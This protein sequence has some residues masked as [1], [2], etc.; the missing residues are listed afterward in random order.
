M[1]EKADRSS[2]GESVIPRIPPSKRRRIQT[3]LRRWWWLLLLLFACCTLIITLPLVYVGFPNIAQ[4][5]VD[6]SSLEITS[7]LLTAP[8]ANSLHIRLDERLHNPSMYHPRLDAFN[9]SLFLEDT[10]PNIKPYAYITV[11]AVHA[12]P[13]ATFTIDQALAV[14][15]MDQFTRYTVLVMNSEEYRLAIRGRTGL[16]QTGLRKTNVNYNEVVTMKGLNKLR[17]FNV[18]EFKVLL[19][20]DPDGANLVGTVFIP[21]P[22]VMLLEMGN[23]TMN[24]FVQGD[25]VGTALLP[26]L[27]LRPGN[28]SVAMRAT[29]NQTAVLQKLALFKDGLVPVDIVGSTAIYH[30]EHLSYYE[31]ALKSNTVSIKLNL[32]AA[33][34][35]LL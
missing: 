26:D 6:D 20:P 31:A 19:T 27:T 24:L 25:A 23:V 29:T 21:N 12:T 30:G 33:L 13:L 11:P 1:S 4:H 3:G 17:G 32:G 8:A 7:M 9:A 15:D 14:A 5:D 18:T 2:Y 34:A 10:E 22:S 28:N 16:H 35:A